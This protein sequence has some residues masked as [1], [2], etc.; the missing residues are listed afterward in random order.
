MVITAEERCIPES[1]AEVLDMKEASQFLRCGLSTLY[2]HVSKH[3]VPCFK[4][5]TRTLFKRSDLLEWLE[6]FRVDSAG[7]S[8]ISSGSREVLS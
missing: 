3:R 5:G 2:Q 4:L 1:S 6:Q 7:A 8:F